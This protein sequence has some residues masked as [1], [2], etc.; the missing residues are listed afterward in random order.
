MDLRHNP[1][2]QL[3]TA[4]V[5]SRPTVQ[6][7]HTP[8]IV[9]LTTMM[10]ILIFAFAYNRKRTTAAFNTAQS[11]Q[12]RSGGRDKHICNIRNICNLRQKRLLS[13]ATQDEKYL[14]Y[15]TEKIIILCNSG[16][17]EV[18]LTQQQAP[19]VSL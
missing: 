6:P 2:L 14:Q 4:S 8:G 11:L 16:W 13:F 1:Q 15:K 3:R 9:F 5:A 12:A 18:G 7:L 10:M 19:L 17:P